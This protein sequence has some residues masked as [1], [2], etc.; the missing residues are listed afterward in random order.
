M[1]AALSPNNRLHISVSA[2]ATDKM[3]KKYLLPHAKVSYEE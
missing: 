3:G 1:S 2:H